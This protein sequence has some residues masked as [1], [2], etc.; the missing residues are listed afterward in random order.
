MV[1]NK[2]ACRLMELMEPH[3]FLREL[4]LVREELK[5]IRIILLLLMNPEKKQKI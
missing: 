2:R 5:Q 4:D 1:E 3:M